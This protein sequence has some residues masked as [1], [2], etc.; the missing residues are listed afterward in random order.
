MVNLVKMQA[1]ITI[2]PGNQSGFA[3]WQGN[4]LV[5]VFTGQSTQPFAVARQTITRMKALGLW[6]DL[7]WIVHEDQ[8]ARSRNTTR[9]MISLSYWTGMLL[10]AIVNQAYNDGIFF[11]VLKVLPETWKGGMSK[12]ATEF[13]ILGKQGRHSRLAD[14]EL[15]CF[16]DPVFSVPPRDRTAKERKIASDLIDA[17]GIGLWY[18]RRF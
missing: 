4:V 3:I 17:V 9:S 7:A 16:T 2:D 10:G 15:T 1:G 5:D 11:K 13:H 12:I 6:E 18:L 8:I 14:T